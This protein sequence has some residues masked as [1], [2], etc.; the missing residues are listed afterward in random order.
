MTRTSK[1]KLS[2]SEIRDAVLERYRRDIL[3]ARLDP[4]RF[5]ELVGRDQQGNPITMAGMHR[6]WQD[7][8]TTHSRVIL[9]GAVG[10]GKSTQVALRLL[11]EIGNNPNI[12]VGIISSGQR[13]QAS[14]LLSQIKGMIES[15]PV[16]ALIFPNLRPSVTQPK[17]TDAAI[18]VERDLIDQ[19]PT[20]ATFGPDSRSIGGAR[21][22]L[23]IF[24][25]IVVDANAFSPTMREK[26]HTWVTGTVLARKPPT[27][28]RIWFL[29]NKWHKDDVVHRLAKNPDY[30]VIESRAFVTN[31]QG[32]EEPA[33]PELWTLED[34]YRNERE[35]GPVLGAMMLRL[36]LP[37]D[38]GARFREEWI[39]SCL[40]KNLPMVPVWDPHDAPTFTGVDL[41]VSGGGDLACLF[42]IAIMPEGTRRVLDI[43][44][45]RW[46]GPQIMQE[47][48]AV[49]QA[50]GSIV[51]VENNAA[52]DY[53]RQFMN[54]IVTVPIKG[55]TTNA[56]KWDL[57]FGV[58][59][60]AT[61]MYQRKW[62]LPADD[63]GNPYPEVAAFISE[64]LTYTPKEHTGD[65][66]MAAWLAREEAR[67]SGLSVGQGLPDE[68]LPL[69]T[70][71]R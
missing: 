31:E 59:S 71:F 33:A 1:R 55:R 43:R 23:M 68:P 28:A 7:A 27:G 50:Y 41:S 57:Q 5:C 69:D 20:V 29:A 63:R 66:L 47:I 3:L 25:D 22:D 15:H 6:Q 67:K 56:N 45:G 58:D 24:D 64:C 53:L 35:L 16:V 38:L 62:A 11:W 48:V 46:Q 65:R 9:F 19:N 39:E 54:E 8:W 17:W 36:K 4:A 34:L 10:H 51:A 30:H 18:T 13:G 44:S 2:A 49:H 42:T 61:E 12:R 40:R 60:L 26:I 14:R 70:L 21:L 37:A 52:Q 32:E